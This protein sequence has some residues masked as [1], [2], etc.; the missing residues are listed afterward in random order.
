MFSEM[1]KNL[2]FQKNFR[3][4]FFF[5]FFSYFLF[6]VVAVIIM[7][8]TDVFLYVNGN[9][10]GKNMPTRQLNWPFPGNCLHTL[11]FVL[12]YRIAKKKVTEHF[13]AKRILG[14]K[15]F[16]MTLIK[17]DTSSSSTICFHNLFCCLKTSHAIESAFVRT[18]IVLIQRNIFKN[19]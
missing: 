2:N 15:L 6:F 12:F 19:K 3:K 13:R 18:K 9:K 7:Q 11:D 10:Y 5:P 8:K 1:W 17:K 14:N 16:M 4:Y